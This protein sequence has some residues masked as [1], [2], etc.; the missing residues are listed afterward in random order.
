MASQRVQKAVSDLVETLS[1]GRL[2]R[3]EKVALWAELSDAASAGFRSA[4][5]DYGAD[6][7]WTALGSALGI[8]RQGAHKRFSDVA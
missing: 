1:R 8:S 2:T 3:A 4:A 6:A 7:G 5:H